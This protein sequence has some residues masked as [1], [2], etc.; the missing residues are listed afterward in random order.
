LIAVVN[1]KTYKL[2]SS[3]FVAGIKEQNTT[4]VYISI[5]DEVFGKFLIRNY[6]RDSVPELMKI[7]SPKYKISVIS[8][9]N[10]SERGNLLKLTQNK[11]ILQF[12]QKPADKLDYIKTLQQKGEKVLMIG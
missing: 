10:A 4:A 8:G 2:G 3:G 9:D 11:A 7:L 6:Y 12:N 5:D 1:G